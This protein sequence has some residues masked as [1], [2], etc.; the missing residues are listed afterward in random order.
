[1]AGT[2][3]E[4]TGEPVLIP[5]SMGA[6]SYI[7]RGL[8][9]ARSMSSASHGAGRAM[10]RGQAMKATEAEFKRFME[11]F[12]IVTPIDPKSPQLRGRVDILRKWEEAIKQEAP[13]AFKEIAPVIDTQTAA[14]LVGAVVELQ[15]I[16]TIKG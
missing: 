8:G 1:M 12:H 2:P 4:W 14:G 16:F 13:W 11:Q 15:P 6:A 3:F 5:G 10:S 9:D 7:L